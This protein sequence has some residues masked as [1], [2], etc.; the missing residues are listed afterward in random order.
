[1]AKKK[2]NEQ[3]NFGS[4]Y[5]DQVRAN[6][7]AAEAR[8]GNPN[9]GRGPDPVN[10]PQPPNSPPGGGGGDGGGRTPPPRKA[11][12]LRTRRQLGGRVETIRMFDD[13]TEEVIDTRVDKSAGEAARDIFRNAGLDD[14]FVNGLMSVIDNVYSENIDPTAAQVLSAIYNSEPYKKRFPANELIRKRIA[15]GVG[16]PGDR[17]LSPKEYMDLEQTYR[18]IFRDS[19]MPEGY[20]DEAADFTKLISNDLS[21]IE[22][23]ERVALAKDALYYA[24]QSIVQTLQDFYGLT[25]GD[26]IAYLLDPDRALTAIETRNARSNRT[27]QIGNNLTDLRQTYQ[28][29]QIGGMGRRAGLQIRKALAEEIIGGGMTPDDNTQRA[30]SAASDLAPDYQRLGEL[31]SESTSSEDLIR[32]ALDLKDGA[33]LGKRRR[34]LASQERA[35]F[36][37]E[38]A[39]G[40]TSLRRIR[41]V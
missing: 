25:T 20:Y 16:R 7:A 37:K 10:E 21:P 8:Y 32:E 23:R 28:A 29:S 14:S 2:Q 15:G 35:Q 3:E 5:Y 19:D 24:D 34:K 41:D 31:Y 17:L 38:S 1:M 27:Q 30:I 26:L 9:Q 39:L 22:M 4:A 33:E 13:G 6:I 11:F 18:Q 12:G 36:A 40:S